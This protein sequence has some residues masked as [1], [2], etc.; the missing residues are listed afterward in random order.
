MNATELVRWWKSVPMKSKKYEQLNPRGA[1]AQLLSGRCG[2]DIELVLAH[3]RKEEARL[4][5]R[6]P[7]FLR[8]VMEI[9]AELRAQAETA[10]VVE[11]ADDLEAEGLGQNVGRVLS[12]AFIDAAQIV[13]G[14]R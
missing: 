3:F 1:V 12:D 13:T 4:S 10:S 9:I 7:D 6:Y 11:L 8:G 5:R 14:D 2:G